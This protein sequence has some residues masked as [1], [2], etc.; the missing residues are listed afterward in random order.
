MLH[1][2]GLN[3]IS[4]K[5]G[6][7]KII[8]DV[9][10]T[11]CS[12]CK[13]SYN[14]QNIDKIG[15]IPLLRFYCDSYLL[16]PQI[17]KSLFTISMWSPDNYV[18]YDYNEEYNS[19]DIPTR[20]KYNIFINSELSNEQYFSVKVFIND[21]EYLFNDEIILYKATCLIKP[22]LYHTFLP[23]ATNYGFINC[24][25]KIR[26]EII[27]YNT[28]KTDFTTLS[29]QYIGEFSIINNTI[30]MEKSDLT[31]NIKTNHNNDKIYITDICFEQINIVPIVVEYEIYSSE[32]EDIINEKNK[33]FIKEQEFKNN[34]KLKYN[35]NIN[36]FT[37]NKLLREK[38]ELDSKIEYYKQSIN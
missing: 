30:H 2:N 25:N 31:Y 8:D 13:N 17:K 37:L 14:I 36:T 10:Y 22:D 15:N 1:C 12:Y 33:E 6:W 20:N 29:N 11:Y 21:I 16:K 27:I 32:S 19:F 35:H 28:Q 18:N 26:L 3:F 9:E 24:N 38:K 5:E 34:I 23:Q 7:V 4:G